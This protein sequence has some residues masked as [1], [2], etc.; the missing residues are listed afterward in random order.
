MSLVE[1]RDKQFEHHREKEE[2]SLFREIF[3]QCSS[4]KIGLKKGF[5]SSWFI[6]F[7]FVLPT[8]IGRRPF[9]SLPIRFRLQLLAIVAVI[10][11]PVPSS[12]LSEGSWERLR[13]IP[14]LLSV[15]SPES[16]RELP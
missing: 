15:P 16:L 7:N 14:W 4:I 12:Y 2:A 6:N 3:V 9:T 1:Y 11:V 10:P 13:P 8:S 5:R